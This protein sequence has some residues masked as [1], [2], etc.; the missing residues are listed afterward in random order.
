MLMPAYLT[1]AAPE[2]TRVL[3]AAV[4]LHATVEESPAARAAAKQHL[5]RRDADG[6]R[7]ASPRQAREICEAAVD[8]WLP[9]IFAAEQQAS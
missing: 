1:L 7:A 3:H 6:Y 2:V 8:G 5:L 9:G 4:S